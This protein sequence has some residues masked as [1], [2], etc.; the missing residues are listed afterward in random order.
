MPMPR[1]VAQI[2]KR[3]FNP[4]QVR[5]EGWPLLTHVGRKSNVEHVTPLDTVP[6]EG[7]YLFFVIYGPESDWVQNVMKTGQAMLRIDGE[8]EL[9]TSPR[10]VDREEAQRL[11]PPDLKFPP[12]WVNV[13]DFLVMSS[14]A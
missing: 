11:A 12:S 3:V 6:V 8:D 7:G 13:K 10:L 9:L 4:P 1:F 14:A 5:K 2:N